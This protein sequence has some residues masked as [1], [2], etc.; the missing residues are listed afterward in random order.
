MMTIGE[1]VKL[2]REIRGISSKEA[3]RKMKVRESAYISLETGL[4]PRYETIKKF[5]DALCISPSF[6]LAEDAPATDDNVLFFD[7]IKEKSFYLVYEQLRQRV[8]VYGELLKI[9]TDD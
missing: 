3:A 6:L 7:K 9:K 2:I 8:D 5:C 1:R 4:N